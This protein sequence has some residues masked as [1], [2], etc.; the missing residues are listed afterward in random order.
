MD[1]QDTEKKSRRENGENISSAI[2]LIGIATS[3]LAWDDGSW[4]GC[5]SFTYPHFP[6]GNALS[7][8]KQL[9]K[10]F[11]DKTAQCHSS[12]LETPNRD[13]WI[14]SL[15]RLQAVNF[16]ELG[17][18]RVP[19]AGFPWLFFIFWKFFGFFFIFVCVFFFLITVL[20]T[21]L[22]TWSCENKSL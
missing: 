5:S 16:E 11:T 12:F 14:G 6:W 17:F 13:P 9:T 21:F 1:E 8:Q 7:H 18:L 15:K 20:G 2:G 22:I 10:I 19:S 4:S 3:L